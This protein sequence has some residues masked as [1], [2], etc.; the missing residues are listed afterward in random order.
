MN[1]VASS[2][3][4]IDWRKK[5]SWY[6]NGKHNECELYQLNNLKIIT[7]KNII[8]TYDRI[9]IADLI[10]SSVRNPLKLKN[11]YD[12]TENFDGTIDLG[13]NKL[14]INLKFV[15]GNGGAQ[16]RTLREV[17]HFI[18][19]Q[20]EYLY[21]NNM[22]NI[23]FINILDGDEANKHICKFQYLVNNKKYNK[24]KSNIYIG[25]TKEFI[26]WWKKLV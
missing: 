2:L 23:Y 9:N 3:Q 18:K 13:K 25:D 14:Y 6:K 17:Y 26:E 21:I 15:C 19:Y 12:Y 8:K 11:G 1:I 22:V 5:Q 16:T 7:N 24:I 10:I 20:L 4:T